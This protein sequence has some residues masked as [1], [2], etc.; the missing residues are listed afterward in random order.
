MFAMPAELDQFIEIMSQN[1][2]PSGGSLVEGRVS[3]GRPNNHWLSRLPKQAKPWNFRQR[4]L[5]FLQTDAKVLEFREFY[6]SQ[7]VQLKFDGYFD[8]FHDIMRR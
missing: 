4:L 7:P 3:P 8:S 5:R 2:L 6:A 1:P